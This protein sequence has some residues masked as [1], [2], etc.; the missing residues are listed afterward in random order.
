MQISNESILVILLV[1]LIAGWLAGKIVRGT[2]F[3]LIGDILVGIA[4]ALV[5]SFL[6][7]K[8]G[9]RLGTGL[10]SEIIYSA[11][12]AIILLLIV[13]LVRTGGRF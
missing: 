5:A 2:G 8:L 10:V 3:G 11:I 6:F 9:I 12:G 4:G 1:G 7:P 13:R